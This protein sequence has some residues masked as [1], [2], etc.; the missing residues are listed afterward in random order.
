MQGFPKRM[1]FDL[2][3][4]TASSTVPSDFLPLH[5]SAGTRNTYCRLITS[6]RKFFESGK[7]RSLLLFL[8]EALLFQY[9]ISPSKLF[10]LNRPEFCRIKIQR[11]IYSKNFA[12][13]WLTGK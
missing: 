6:L 13:S 12:K 9:L 10:D 5:L 3:K 11:R 1:K 7:F 4:S 2:Q 8:S